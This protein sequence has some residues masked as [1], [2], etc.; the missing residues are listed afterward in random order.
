MSVESGG[1]W[2]SD[3]SEVGEDVYLDIQFDSGLFHYDSKELCCADC[4][5][6]NLQQPCEACPNNQ[7]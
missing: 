3:S 1:F 7:Y 5:C 2:G 4:S 6:E